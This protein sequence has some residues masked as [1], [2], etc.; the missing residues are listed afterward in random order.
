M[1]DTTPHGVDWSQRYGAQ[2]PHCQ[3]Y[4]KESYKH[5]EW[6]TSAGCKKR[7]HKCPGCGRNFF[8]IS[9]DEASKGIEPTPEQLR[10]LRAYEMKDGTVRRGGIKMPDGWLG[11]PGI[12]EAVSRA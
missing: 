10:F 6:I 4:T 12:S 7:Y 5:G 8:S 1:T 3:V 2:C 11:L 9:R